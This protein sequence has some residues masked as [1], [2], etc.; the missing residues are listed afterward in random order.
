MGKDPRFSRLV[1]FRGPRTTGG[2]QRA[3]DPG[4]EDWNR[5][6]TKYTQISNAVP[7]ELGMHFQNILN[8]NDI[9]LYS[10]SDLPLFGSGY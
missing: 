10:S 5:E 2:R 3:G 1:F 9:K 4:I 7:V 6:V 8:N